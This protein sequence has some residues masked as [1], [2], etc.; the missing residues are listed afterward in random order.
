MNGE[1][2]MKSIDDNELSVDIIPEGREDEYYTEEETLEIKRKIKKFA[3]SQL[4]LICFF[5]FLLIRLILSIFYDSSEW[6]KIFSYV[7]GVG[8]IFI[9]MFSIIR[10]VSVWRLINKLSKNNKQ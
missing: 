6:L 5:V 7:I 9:I 1:V 10:Y 2:L 3:N 8:G 4:L